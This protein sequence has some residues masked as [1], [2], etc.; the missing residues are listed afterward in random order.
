[1]RAGIWD[2]LFTNVSPT[3]RAVGGV[4]I[5][6]VELLQ[7]FRDRAGQCIIIDKRK[8]PGNKISTNK[9]KISQDKS[10]HGMEYCTF[11]KSHI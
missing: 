9:R 10:I 8:T 7:R 5:I 11:V 2:Y 1:M 6:V 4:Q 3:S